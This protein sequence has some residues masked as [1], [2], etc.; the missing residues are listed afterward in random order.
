M[1]SIRQ[2]LLAGAMCLTVVALAAQTS[3]GVMSS[4]MD[5]HVLSQTDWFDTLTVPK[6]NSALGT[7]TSVKVTF[8]G[9]IISDMT[10]DNDNTTSVNAIGGVNVNIFGTFA[11]ESLAINP[12]ASTG[13][14]SMGADDSGD[15]DGPGDG[16]PDEVTVPNIAGMDMQMFTPADLSPYIGG[17]A[18]TLSTM[19]LGTLAGF[20]VS[21]GGGNVDVNVN[22]F[23]SA[24][25]TVDYTFDT[26]PPP[27][28]GIP[29]PLTTTLLPLGALALA[30]SLWRRRG[31][32]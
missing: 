12:T 1:T 21:G 26:V 27:T 17:A 13:L 2:K 10:L 29:E 28:T 8:M 23:A 24:K 16:G 22:T 11:G 4:F 31:T 32:A 5:E 20:G 7:L 15:T 9:D 19:N 6:F 25:I 18:D 3:R 30:G 14:V